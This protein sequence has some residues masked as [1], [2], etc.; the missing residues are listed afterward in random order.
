MPPTQWRVPGPV[1]GYRH[2]GD[3]TALRPVMTT[4]DYQPAEPVEGEV[5]A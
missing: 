5:H 2:V 1:S 3:R 4:E